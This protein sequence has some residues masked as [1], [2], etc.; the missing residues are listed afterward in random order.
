MPVNKLK[1]M[2][3]GF[4]AAVAALTGTLYAALNAN[5]F[6][7][8]F[9]FVLLITRVGIWWVIHMWLGVS[10]F[11]AVIGVFLSYLALPPAL[12]EGED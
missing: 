2:S 10:F 5:V 7:L 11:A 3:F 4:G 6:P 9:Y 1:L 12:P 8:T